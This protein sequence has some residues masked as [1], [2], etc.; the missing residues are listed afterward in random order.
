[1]KPLW[2]DLTL[3]F[4]LLLTL[5]LIAIYPTTESCCCS[6]SSNEDEQYHIV[7]DERDSLFTRQKLQELYLK[8]LDKHIVP[9]GLI[10]TEAEGTEDTF[11]C[12]RSE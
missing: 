6:A 10:C 4:V 7:V 5:I 8:A 2:V 12:K 1:M 9:E 3:I 11:Y